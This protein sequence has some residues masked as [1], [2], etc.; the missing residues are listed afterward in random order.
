MKTINDV[1]KYMDS[2]NPHDNVKRVVDVGSN[3]NVHGYMVETVDEKGL[4]SAK[5]L[6]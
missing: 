2:I 3:Y 5:I 1:V 4:C 6:Y